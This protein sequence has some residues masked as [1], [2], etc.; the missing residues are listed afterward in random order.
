MFN[1]HQTRRLG[2][3]FLLSTTCILSACTGESG[4]DTHSPSVDKPKNI[5]IFVG[6]G[7]GISTV[8]AA[9]IF[10]GQQ[11][12]VDGE[13]HSLSFEAFPEAALIKTYN[14]NAQ[15]PDSAGT[16]TAIFSGYKANIGTVNIVPQDDMEAMAARSCQ[17]GEPTLQQRAQSAG[18]SVGVIS[19][20]RLTHATPAAVYGRAL[21]RSWEGDDRLPEMMISLGCTSLS[22]QLVTSG[23]DLALGGGSGV[24]TDAQRALWPGD[25]VTNT[26]ELHAASDAPVLGLFGRSHMDYEADRV[27]GEQ[28]S[29]ADM[30]TIA[31]DRLSKDEDGFVL[32]VEAGRVDHAHHGTNAFR[33][34]RDMQA[35]NDAVAAAVEKGGD[36]TLI[37]VTADHSHVFVIQGYPTF[38]NPIMGLVRT[39]DFDRETMSFT[40]PLSTDLDG[41]P[42]TTLGYYNGPNVRSGEAEALDDETVSSPDYQQ[43]TAIRM[44]SE[45]HSGEDVPLYATGPGAENF[46]GVM[47]QDEIGQ[48]IAALLK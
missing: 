24:V 21:D 16:A 18:K 12:G 34:M 6:D 42:Y 48:A 35:L 15:V 14:S 44:R 47:D 11:K 13:T 23:L 8:T 36:D 9:R 7:M 27:D 31:M 1:F 39:N 3:C 29:L 25:V 43:Q 4:A 30:T 46:G 17:G 26:S 33:A 41:K 28:P 2:A 45:T 19:T 40:T 37:V 32:M 5:I 38:G 10:D 20:A 22:Q